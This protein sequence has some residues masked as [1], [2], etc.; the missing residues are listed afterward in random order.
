VVSKY[1]ITAVPTGD[2]I[3]EK[4][5]S[6]NLTITQKLRFYLTRFCINRS[7]INIAI[8]QLQLEILNKLGVRVDFVIPNGIEKCS[9]SNRE[10]IFN[11]KSDL[12]VLFAGRPLLKGLDILIKSILNSSYNWTIH[13]AGDPSL[14]D[15]ATKLSIKNYIYHGPLVREDLFKLYH[16]VDLVFV[17]SQY[18]DA[19]PL[20]GL[21]A[22]M[23][24][25]P[26][27]TTNLCGSSNIFKDDIAKK[28]VI[29]S[30]TIP[31]LDSTFDY[32]K[33]NYSRIINSKNNIKDVHEILRL[34]LNHLI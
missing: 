20:I 17:C 34:Y 25:T 15:Y 2:S 14:L 22:L 30:Q 24:H 21:E 31:D 32:I 28:L 11:E 9:H 8:S 18:L 33:A 12:Q 23:H 16:G 7:S 3:Y 5:D 27:I 19:G 29:N 13:L 4:L 6:L 10:K 26:F 1:K